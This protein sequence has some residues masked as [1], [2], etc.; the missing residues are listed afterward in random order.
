MLKTL[1]FWLRNARWVALPQSLLPALAG[2]APAVAY[3]GFSAVLSALAVFGVCMAHLS[4]N[5]F[6]DYFDF[7]KADTGGRD[8]LARAGMRART[9]KCSY[10]LSGEATIG[11]LL[12]AAL[13][14][15]G[16]A[17]LCGIVIFLHRGMP[18]VWIALITGFL[19]IAYSAGPL[20]L[21]YRG[22]GELTLG[23]IFG[24]LLVTGVHF[25][26][27]GIIGAQPLI[28]G[29]ALGFLVVSILYTHSLL[30]LEADKSVG[31]LTLAG[32]VQNPKHR[33][34]L[35][36]VFLFTPYIIFVTGVI[37]QKLT[38][39]SC[40]VFLTLPLT[41]ALVRSVMQFMKNPDAVALRKAWHGPMTR[42]DEIEEEGIGWFMLRWYLARNILTA[43]ALLAIFA[44]LLR[45]L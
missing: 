6:D 44:A 1:L 31:K 37:F 45:L 23:V 32:L 42:W 38:V 28:L 4:L 10:L 8:R 29:T 40:L 7:K 41:V 9:G 2:V 33:I 17:G 13:I 43:F 15:G 24:P 12:T 18:V 36:C 26:A 35:L 5:L 22:L 3:E 39:W 34:G 30:D 27:S 14:F 19:G 21:S 11:N 16:M 20:R 25:A